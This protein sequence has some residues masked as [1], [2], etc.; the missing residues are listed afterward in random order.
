VRG[1]AAIIALALSWSVVAHA[2]P[3]ADQQIAAPTSQPPPLSSPPVRPPPGYP[4]HPGGE[5][6]GPRP[7][8]ARAAAFSAKLAFGGSL[9]SFAGRTIYGVAPQLSLG[10]QFGD[11]GA[12]HAELGLMFGAAEAL[13]ARE[14]SVGA[15]WEFILWRFRL[16]LGV[17]YQRVSFER[18]TRHGG[19]SEDGY[20]RSAGSMIAQGPA[21][22]GAIDFDLY[23]SDHFNLYLGLQGKLG[24]ISEQS[25]IGSGALRLGTRF[26]FP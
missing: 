20:T 10:V 24:A 12:L 26:K 3:H 16:G 8:R 13:P 2:Q 18:A 6:L 17:H 1:H 15:S 14:L 22:S 7:G 21:L 4:T 9:G 25:G 23:Q 11:F 5:W 19:F